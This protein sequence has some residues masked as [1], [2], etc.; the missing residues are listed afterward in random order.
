MLS[1]LAPLTDN[2]D[3]VGAVGAP[4]RSW[5]SR[6]SYG[7]APKNINALVPAILDDVAVFRDILKSK[8][9]K[10][11]TWGPVL[12]LEPLTTNLMFDIIA[13]AALGLRLHEQ[14]DGPSPIMRAM[15]DQLSTMIF[16]Y[17]IITLPQILSPARQLKMLRNSRAMRDFLVPSV[18]AL[19]NDSNNTSTKGNSNTIF[20]LAVRA[21]RRDGTPSSPSPS[22]STASASASAS[23][24]AR[25]GDSKATTATAT[26]TAA[27]ADKFLIDTLIS[28]LKAFIFAGHDTTAATTCWVLHSLADSP[29][30][31]AALRAEL[32][33]VFGPDPSQLVPKL[34]AQPQLLQ[35]LQY[36]AAFV[37]EALRLH[38]SAP[39][40]RVSEGGFVFLN[41]PGDEERPYYPTKGFMLWDA[42]MAGQRYEG[43]WARRNEFLPERW[44]VGPGDELYVKTKIAWRFFGTGPRQCIGQELAMTELKLVLIAVA[45][46]VDI[47]CAW[48]EWDE[49]R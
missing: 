15:T 44:L 12:A 26:T 37:K 5:R 11:G 13:R 27:P 33:A 16:E 10:A 39:Q 14:T 20:D 22:P 19:L 7:F 31:T 29:R 17:N 43:V 35:Q 24:C 4:W 42:V 48:E 2:M 49:V 9:G 38:P 18:V 32:D 21:Y 36:T 6:L 34:N 46:E 28:N 30:A 1:Y 8:T 3:I 41:V 25:V 47:E 23:A 40:I 45:R